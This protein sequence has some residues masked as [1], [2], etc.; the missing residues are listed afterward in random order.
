MEFG[1]LSQI[2]NIE[3]KHEMQ[4]V[5]IYPDMHNILFLL[6]GLFGGRVIPGGHHLTRNSQ[7]GGRKF[8]GKGTDQTLF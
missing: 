2:V 6:F 3:C 8:E 4:V 5:L 7:V 1:L